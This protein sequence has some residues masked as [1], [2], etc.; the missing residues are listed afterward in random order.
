MQIMYPCKRA[1][2]EIYQN[3]LDLEKSILSTPA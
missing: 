2:V 3:K 1:H